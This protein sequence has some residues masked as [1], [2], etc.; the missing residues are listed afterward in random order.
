MHLPRLDRRTHLRALLGL[1][2]APALAACARH[3]PRVP[4]RPAA[5]AGS[6]GADPSAEL[7]DTDDGPITIDRLDPQLGPRDAHAV[8]VIFSDF[9]CPFCRDIA[10]VMAKIRAESPKDV[11]LVFKHLP[12]PMHFHARAASVAAQV[13]FLEG[14]TDAFWRFHDRAFAHQ[15]DIDQSVLFAWARDEGVRAEAITERG[16]EAER[17]V[18]DDIALAERLSIHGTPHLYV[19]GRT[20]AGAYPYEQMR[21]WVDEVL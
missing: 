14:G 18:S 15:S 4:T 1:V 9:Q 16:P 3:Q 5:R 8:V 2:A 21:S 20:I 12:T 17:R 13:V 11:R 19:N 10:A 6:P 7:L